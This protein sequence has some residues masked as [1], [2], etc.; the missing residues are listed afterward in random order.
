MDKDS[1]LAKFNNYRSYGIYRNILGI[2]V[3]KKIFHVILKKTSLVLTR[4]IKA[5]LEVESRVARVNEQEKKA[6]KFIG[7]SD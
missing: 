7:G 4:V 2:E 1:I 6:A 3:S 5:W